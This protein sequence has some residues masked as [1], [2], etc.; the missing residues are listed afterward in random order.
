MNS[1]EADRRRNW[2]M[3]GC[4]LNQDMIECIE[5]KDYVYI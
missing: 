5:D 1:S 4:F 2:K 3:R